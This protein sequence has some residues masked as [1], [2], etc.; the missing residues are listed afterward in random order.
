[1]QRQRGPSRSF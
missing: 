1:M